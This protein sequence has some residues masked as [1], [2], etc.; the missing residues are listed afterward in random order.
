MKW[1]AGS[2][3]NLGGKVSSRFQP[4]WSRLLVNEAAELLLCK[5][6]LIRAKPIGRH[7]S[8]SCPFGNAGIF[9]DKDVMSNIDPALKQ[10][11]LTPLVDRLVV[12]CNI[13]WPPHFRT[14]K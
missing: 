4:K 10:E 7:L 6:R 13:R 1:A 9:T 3:L 5:L 8:E 14:L 2:Y 12:A 11:L